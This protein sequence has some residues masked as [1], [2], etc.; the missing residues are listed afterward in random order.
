MYHELTDHFV[1]SA[2][3]DRTWDFFSRA[4][5]L[6]LI[7]PRWLHF[8][9]L[10][11]EPVT[12]ENNALLDYT[13]RWMGAPIHWRT[14]IIDWQPPHSFIDLQVKGPYVLWHHQHTFR[15]APDGTVCTDRVIY[16][17]PG[18]PLGAVLNAALIRGQLLD[19]FRY[20]RKVISEHLGWV[21]GVQDDVQVNPLS[22]CP[23]V[24]DADPASQPSG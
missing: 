16:K 17:V 20:R 23:P 14:L 7:T 8:R 6:P 18:G 22:R 4:E 3:L 13:I 10:T 15:P 19:I 9:L 12:I 21:R 5:N 2:P 11:P 1:V 24:P